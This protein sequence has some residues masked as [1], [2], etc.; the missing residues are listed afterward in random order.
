MRTRRVHLKEDMERIAHHCGESNNSNP[1]EELRMQVSKAVAWATWCCARAVRV[2]N[3]EEH[4]MRD[5]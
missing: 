4:G 2:A 1:T 3:A 5:Q